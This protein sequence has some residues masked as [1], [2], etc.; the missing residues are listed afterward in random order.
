MARRTFS[1]TSKRRGECK[2]NPLVVFTVKKKALWLCK[3]IRASNNFMQFEKTPMKCLR[4]N[5]RMKLIRSRM[6]GF[7]RCPTKST[8]PLEEPHKSLLRKYLIPKWAPKISLSRIHPCLRKRGFWRKVIR[9]G[10]EMVLS[11]PDRGATFPADSY[12]AYLTNQKKWEV[13]EWFILEPKIGW[14]R[15][16]GNLTPIRQ[17]MLNFCTTPEYTTIFM[18][19]TKLKASAFLQVNTIIWIMLSRFGAETR[20]AWVQF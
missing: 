6:K 3:K 12:P 20:I 4:P 9:V 2:N 13:A 16:L 5:N 15:F 10:W 7:W 18:I 17:M 11:L 1:E 8:L 19:P 14:C